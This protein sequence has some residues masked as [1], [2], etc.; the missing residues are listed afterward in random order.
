MRPATSWDRIVSSQ[1]GFGILEFACLSTGDSRDIIVLPIEV[2]I[3]EAYNVRL[4]LLDRK[5]DIG[6]RDIRHNVK[7]NK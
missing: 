6:N 7:G 1:A 2:A 3:V 5:D 4:P